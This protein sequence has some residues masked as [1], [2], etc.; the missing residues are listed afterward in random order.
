MEEE[1]KTIER[2]SLQKQIE[3]RER[4]K[5][6]LQTKLTKEITIKC[7]I[8][9]VKQN[10]VDLIVMNGVPFQL[11]DSRAFQALVGPILKALGCNPI[12]RHNAQNL[13]RSAAANM[14]EK[15]TKACRNRLIN[16]KIDCVT[17]HDKSYL[18]I[19]AQFSA[20]QETVFYHLGILQLTTDHTGEVLKDTI[21]KCLS[22]FGIGVDQILTVVTD[23]VKK[24]VRLLDELQKTLHP[25]RII[26]K[27]QVV[28]RIPSQQLLQ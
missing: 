9:E 19:N 12:N 8:T 7:S 11:M 28:K 17:R 25:K 26:M 14:T 18:G 10:I 4:K 2:Q 15:I 20:N 1:K 23:N 22:K 21:I 3:A 16:L 13:I 27:A 5:K 24:S 6:F